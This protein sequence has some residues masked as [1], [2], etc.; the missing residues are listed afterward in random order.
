MTEPIVYV[1]DD[2]PDVLDSLEALLG[3]E[4]FVVEKF[5]SGGELLE[6]FAEAEPKGCILCDVRMPGMTGLEVQSAL[7][8][9]SASPPI[10]FMTGHS[11]LPLAVEAMKAG[12]FDFVE[13]PIDDSFLVDRLNKAN[14]VGLVRR[15]FAK[16]AAKITENISRLTPR[17]REV[18]DL[19][20]EGHPNKIIAFKLDIS[21]RTV[22]IHRSRVME[23]MGANSLS[24]LVR[25]S[26]QVEAAKI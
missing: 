25:M 19:L 18:M 17:E 6:H 26:L 11:E 9:L 3:A 5:S 24:H 1:V 8:E 2:D 4:G 20:V 7:N 13:K 12:A 23:K 22:E 16:E 14:E 21:A 15:Q 10:I